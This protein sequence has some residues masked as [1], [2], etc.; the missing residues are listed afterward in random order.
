MPAKAVVKIEWYGAKERQTEECEKSVYKGLTQTDRLSIVTIQGGLSC[1]CIVPESIRFFFII[2]GNPTAHLNRACCS[3]TV[4][5]GTQ[6]RT[7]WRNSGF[8]NIKK[9]TKS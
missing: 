5:T 6:S 8:T 1:L 9:K 4:N 3:S 7:K 2:R